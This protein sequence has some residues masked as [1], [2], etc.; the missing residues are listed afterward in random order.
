MSRSPSK[1]SP[2]NLEEEFT[3]EHIDRNRNNL[4]LGMD[5]LRTQM[6]ICAEIVQ[7][8]R[9]SDNAAEIF[10]TIATK[11]LKNFQAVHVS[12]YK[13][14]KSSKTKKQSIVSGK[15]VA[16]AIAPYCESCSQVYIENIL[17]QEY[18]WGQGITGTAID[19]YSANLTQCD[20]NLDEIFA[21]KAFLLIPIF[22]PEANQ[23][24]PLWGFLTVHQCSGFDDDCRGNWDQDD[25]LMLKQVATQIE[26]TLQR[27]FHHN[28][29]LQQLEEADQAYAILYRWTQQY[30]TLVEQFP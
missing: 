23:D 25:V 7:K 2:H 5:K 10:E 21:G 9:H 22:L 1:L 27:E 14:D 13:L 8:V 29:M 4:S 16:K 17:S 6:S 19:F 18:Q 26:I 28:S 12:I 3:K 20:L 15:I 30:R 24:R 11:L